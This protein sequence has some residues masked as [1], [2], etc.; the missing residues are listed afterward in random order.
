MTSP[1]QSIGAAICLGIALSS[2]AQAGI[3]VPT[4]TAEAGPPIDATI[5]PVSASH[6]SADAAAAL[7]ACG[8]VRSD[9]YGYG[10]GIVSGMGLVSPG[11]N[12]NR[13]AAIGNTPET[14]IDSPLWVITTSGNVELP[15]GGTLT[16]P[17]CIVAPGSTRRL[18]LVTGPS[19]GTNGVSTTPMP[20]PPAVL[21]LPPLAP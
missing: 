10:I 7:T 12:A 9:G 18:W 8:I 16:D 6:P 2:C 1:R 13:Y 19:V 20:Q 21:R 14:Q 11:R 5:A 4:T 17:T 15:L 3:A